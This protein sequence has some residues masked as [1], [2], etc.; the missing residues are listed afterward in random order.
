MGHL[1]HMGQLPHRRKR[2]I[3][4]PAASNRRHPRSLLPSPSISSTPDPQHP[5]YLKHM[6]SNR[7]EAACMRLQQQ[8]PAS[9]ASGRR[10]AGH[11]E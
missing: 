7:S 10:R 4:S 8:A 1:P 11:F 3:A 6:R 2:V 5:E 9:L